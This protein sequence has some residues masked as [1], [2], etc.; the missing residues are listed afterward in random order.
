MKVNQN[1]ARGYALLVAR[2]GHDLL[3]ALEA[4]VE[5][6]MPS[7]ET[8][9]VQ[10]TFFYTCLQNVAI[11]TDAKTLSCIDLS[12]RQ[13]GFR[14]PADAL[15]LA[16]LYMKLY[17]L[18]RLSFNAITKKTEVVFSKDK[19]FSYNR[20][21]STRHYQP[22]HRRDPELLEICKVMDANFGKIVHMRDS[23]MRQELP[24]WGWSAIKWD[25]LGGKEE[26][27]KRLKLSYSIPDLQPLL[28]PY[29]DTKD[30]TS[31]HVSEIYQDQDLLCRLQSVY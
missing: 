19:K 17:R 10:Y 29:F 23:F 20:D 7:I 21:V 26:N 9:K 25:R 3:K 11:M 6:S 18:S 16:N 8:A 2:L 30:E 28:G 24:T 14:K 1:F 22:I 27:Q 4:A 15:Y 12:I 31:Q 5:L 13:I